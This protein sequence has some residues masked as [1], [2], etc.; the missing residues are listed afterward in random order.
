M[1]KAMFSK[2]DRNRD[3]KIDASELK[4]FLEAL[5]ENVSASN[6]HDLLKE[7]DTDLDGVSLI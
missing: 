6:V 3:G 5:G 1:C 2:A 7:I 4:N